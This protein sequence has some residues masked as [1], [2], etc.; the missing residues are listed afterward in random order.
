VSPLLLE[1]RGIVHGEDLMMTPI[2]SIH[3]A[4]I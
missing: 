2:G 1:L 3:V 4:N